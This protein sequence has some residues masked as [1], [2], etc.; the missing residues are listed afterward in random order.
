MM[1]RSFRIAFALGV[2]SAGVCARPLQST[3]PRFQGAPAAT[4][5]KALYQALNALQVNG[6]RVFTV[7]ELHLKRSAFDITLNEGKLAFLKPLDNRVTG[8][9]FTG[10]GSIV[11]LPRDPAERR[12]LAE[13]LGVPILDQP[14]SRAYLRFTDD[15]AVVLEDHLE[16]A[17]TDVAGDPAFADIWN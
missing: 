5:P 11:A 6:S 12:S 13:F 17:K 14:F 10:R 4:D 3:N 16:A 9:V 1:R 2:L 7:R 15:T 8:A